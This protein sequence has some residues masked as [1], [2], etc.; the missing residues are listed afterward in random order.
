MDVARPVLLLSS[1]FETENERPEERGV[2]RNH[3]QHARI[4]K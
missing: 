1:I 4:K 2:C 3:M